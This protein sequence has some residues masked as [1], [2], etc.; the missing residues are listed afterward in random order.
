MIK[1]RNILAFNINFKSVSIIILEPEPTKY[2]K[3][4]GDAARLVNNKK[5]SQENIDT[6]GT[7]DN[8]G[9]TVYTGNLSI[10][11]FLQE[12]KDVLNINCQPH[13]PR[14]FIG[15]RKYL[16]LYSII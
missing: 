12:R 5:W 9:Y 10:A 14:S 3:N 15:K 11:L 6:F 13:R 4:L 2:F 7:A 16:K 8:K 1:G